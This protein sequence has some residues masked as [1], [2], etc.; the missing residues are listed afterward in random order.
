VLIK[1]IFFVFLETLR[2]YPPAVATDRICHIDYKIPGTDFVLKKGEGVLIP[3]LGL[4]H[5]PEFYPQP[6]KFNPERFSPKNKNKINPYAFLA[7][8]QGP[9]NCI[10]ELYQFFAMHSYGHDQ[11]L[12]LEFLFI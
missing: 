12:K 1:K 8:G 6:E 5:D 11:F 2:F 4:H 7:F 9:R 3:I 10:G